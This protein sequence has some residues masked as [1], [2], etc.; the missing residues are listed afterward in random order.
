[1]PDQSD[2]TLQE[3]IQRKARELWLADGKPPGREDQ[4]REQA[5][6]ILAIK[7]GE[8]LTHLPRPTQ[9]GEPTES[10]VA[11]ENQASLPELTDQADEPVAPSRKRQPEPR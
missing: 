5:K 3:R 7:E 6:E 4:Y 10:P 11:I 9:S 2:E 8:R 1:M